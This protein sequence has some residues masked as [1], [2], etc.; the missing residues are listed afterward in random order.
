MK[1]PR[2]SWCSDTCVQ[3][4]KDRYDNAHQRRQVRARDKGVCQKCALDTQK[5]AKEARALKSGPAA[6]ELLAKHGFKPTD[7]GGNNSLWQADH[8]VPVVEGGGGVPWQAL[9][10]LC[11]PCHRAETAAL[12]AR[13]RAEKKA[14]GLTPPHG[15]KRL[16]A[17]GTPIHRRTL[18]LSFRREGY[19]CFPE[20]QDVIPL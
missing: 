18:L 4:Y 17:H 2:Q 12:M 14:G 13:R 19:G 8:T 9:R 3:D 20:P 16:S 11:K 6:I 15:L 1:P 5:L 10:T 7:L